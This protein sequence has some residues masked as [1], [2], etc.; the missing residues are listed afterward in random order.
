MLTTSQ[1]I[2]SACLLKL[3]LFN[4]CLHNDNRIISLCWPPTVYQ[5]LGHALS[6][7]LLFFSHLIFPTAPWSVSGSVLCRG[8]CWGSERKSDLPKVICSR[9]P[10]LISLQLKVDAIDHG[11]SHPAVIVSQGLSIH[12][13][14]LPFTKSH[15]LF[16]VCPSTVLFNIFLCFLMVTKENCKQFFFFLSFWCLEGK[17]TNPFKIQFMQTAGVLA[18]CSNGEVQKPRRLVKNLLFDVSTAC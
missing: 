13:F 11:V 4:S 7:S 1:K 16:H 8:E 3:F 15:N 6:E 14:T 17:R 5:M 2:G 18:A 10:N 12:L 9:N